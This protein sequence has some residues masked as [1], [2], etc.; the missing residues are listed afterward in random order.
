MEL[1][2]CQKLKKEI[3]NSELSLTPFDPPLD[4][5]KVSDASQYGIGAILLHKF[6]DGKQS[7]FK[8][9]GTSREYL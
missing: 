8:N 1:V 9:I 7:L 6:E 4:K 2:G 5:I 3:L